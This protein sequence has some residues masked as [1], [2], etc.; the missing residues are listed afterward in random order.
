MQKIAPFLWFD[1]PAE[2]AARFYASIF[3]DSSVDNV[4]TV[5][6]DTPSGPEGAVIV[7]EFTL[8]GAP[9]MAME[10]GAHHDFNDAL[11]LFVPCKDQAEI[12]RYWDALLQGGGKPLAC[13]WLIDRYGVRWQICPT[14]L[15]EMEKSPDKAAA[16]RAVQAM[17]DMV[18]LDLATLRR[19]YEGK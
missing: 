7:V 16:R 9:Y 4:H 5:P 15:I 17:M 12:D 1:T 14:E 6:A 13:G 2:E 18:K 8:M 19:A 11:S 10:A 3:P